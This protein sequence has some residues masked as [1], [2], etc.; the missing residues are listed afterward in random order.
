MSDIT[1]GLLTLAPAETK[2]ASGESCRSILK[3]AEI[4]N[5]IREKGFQV[6]SGGDP[7]PEE[8]RIATSCSL[9]R[10]HVHTLMDFDPAC[11]IIHLSLGPSAGDVVSCVR[12][13]QRELRAHPRIVLYADTTGALDTR[14]ALI[15]A[16][17]WAPL[18]LGDLSQPDVVEALCEGVRFQAVRHKIVAIS[19]ELVERSKRQKHLIWGGLPERTL[20]DAPDP[21]ELM[22]CFGFNLE[23][24][25][26]DELLSRAAALGEGKDT[27]VLK[28]LDCGAPDPTAAAM[29]FAAHDLMIEHEASSSSVAGSDTQLAWAE[30]ILLADSHPGL[31]SRDRMPFIRDADVHLSLTA[32]LMDRLTGQAVQC[33]HLVD[34][35]WTLNVGHAP[36]PIHDASLV[37]LLRTPRS[38]CLR[39]IEGVMDGKTFQS[40]TQMHD[41]P[42]SR[43]ILVPT[44]IAPQVVEFAQASGIA[45][46]V[47][48]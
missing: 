25:P 15:R 19:K 34:D 6:V 16:G 45:A 47:T 7:Y 28:T 13:L 8:D 5:A 40:D 22:R 31:S 11:T 48:T 4:A 3:E 46:Q 24:R 12:Y 18:V 41:L 27:R 10:R 32:W 39:V 26:V 14:A 17:F 42:S 44:H 37:R 33:A 20:Y 2:A 38:Y 9:A 35:N 43:W 30:S 36:A 29:S 21:D 1:V 23:A